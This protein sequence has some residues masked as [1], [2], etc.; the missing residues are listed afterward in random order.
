MTNE[1][2]SKSSFG[3]NDENPKI[4]YKPI[5]KIGNGDFRSK[6]RTALYITLLCQSL[7]LCINVS[8]RRVYVDEQ[9][10]MCTL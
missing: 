10:V 4:W 9:N 7:K 8:I 1:S 5:F 6:S 2:D 3:K